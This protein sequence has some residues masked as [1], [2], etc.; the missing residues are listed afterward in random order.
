MRAIAT[1]YASP[2]LFIVALATF[3]GCG[4][5]VVVGTKSSGAGG[6]GASGSGAGG[7]GGSGGSTSGYAACDG[8]G[9]CVLVTNGCCES[10]GPEDLSTK[11]AVNVAQIEAF[12]ASVC[13]SPQP[14]PMCASQPN[15]NLFAYCDQGTC[16]AADVREHPVSACTADSDCQLRFGASCCGGCVG[17]TSQLT[18]INTS[19]DLGALVCASN[20][21]CPDCVPVFPPDAI[22]ACF[23]GHCEVLLAGLGGE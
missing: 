6:S 17:D 7:V 19:G 12:R 5:D 3:E 22:T 2:L 4:G 14:C 8:P 20:T 13:P 1:L 15:P 9:Q 18:A 10:C 21:P 23:D 16:R 11:A